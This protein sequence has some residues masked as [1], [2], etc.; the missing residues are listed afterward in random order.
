MKKLFTFSLTMALS[1]LLHAATLVTLPAGVEPEDYTL[2]IV[3]AIYQ[4]G[5]YIDNSKEMTTKVAF[6]GNDVYV[7]GLAY[8]FPEAYVK[9][10]LDGSTVTFASAQFVGEDMYGEEYLSSYTLN[11]DDVVPCDFVM[12]YDT[13]SRTLTVDA[14]VFVGETSEP[15]GGGLYAYVKAA[16]FTPGALPP[17]VKVDVP[18][19]L[20]TRPYLLSA[21][22]MAYD[23]A[24]DGST[25][26]R[27][28]PYQQPVAVGLD[29]DDLYIQGLV[30]NV[31]DDWVKAT[32]NSAG[33]YVIP[34]G[35]YVGT[36]NLYGQQFYDFYVTSF[37]RNNQLT[38]IVLTYNEADQ[39]VTTTQSI[40]MNANKS[41]LQAY[42]YLT[43]VSL[44][45]MI[46][47]EATPAE[48]SFTFSRE[49]SPYG[50][51]VWYFA[52]MF[53]PLT[54]TAGEPLLADKLS[55]IFYAEKDGQQQPVV[56]Q[57]SKYYM[58]DEDISELPYSFTDRL[59]ISNHTVYFEKMGEEE[60]RSW[61]RLGLQTI[62]RGQ[63]AEHR[64][65]IVWFDMAAFWQAIDGIYNPAQDFVPATRQDYDLQGRRISDDARGLVLRRSV[66][67]DGTVK[68]VKVIKR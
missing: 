3:H 47:R 13:D 63:G 68:T 56:F 67:A 14:S 59:D 11:G 41:S 57:A 36:S 48:P 7:A 32:K 53:I 60:L 49:P 61:T 52:D 10:T 26:L 18:E 65:A 64:S 35:Q 31:P 50:S 5:G 25:V 51:T 17:L 9:G 29:G 34:S 28:D 19:G 2:K 58:L 20:T 15:N 4:S 8:Y 23:T 22:Y 30:E 33:Q 12:H 6:S 1:T 27:N 45:P 62:Y 54:D 39:S 21:N 40:A 43:N 46:E 44:K 16:V 38:D 66:G 37:N 55:Y 42:Y 24:A